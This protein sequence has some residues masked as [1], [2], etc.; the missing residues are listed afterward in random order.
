LLI[1]QPPRLVAIDSAS[2]ARI[3]YDIR[4]ADAKRILKIFDSG[5]VVPLFTEFHV[6]E[7]VRHKNDTVFRSRV[8]LIRSLPFVAFPKRPEPIGNIGNSLE[9]RELEMRVLLDWPDAT[10]DFV[11]DKVRPKLINGFARGV[12]LYDSNIK[13]WI[14]YRKNF[15][16]YILASSADIA[17]FCHFPT[18]NA[19]DLDAPL[20]KSSKGLALRSKQEIARLINESAGSLVHRLKEDGDRRLLRA[21][22]RLRPAE[23]IA[24]E[25]L[26]HVYESTAVLHEMDGDFFE[27]LLRSA[28]IERDRLPPNPTYGDAIYETTFVPALGVHE[29]RL[30][31]PPGRLRQFVRQ[32]RVPSWIVWRQTNQ[33]MK[34]LKK[35]EGSSLNDAMIVPFALYIDAV[36]VDKRVFHCVQHR[37]SRHPLMDTVIARLFCS[38][39][40]R[41]L[42]SKLETM[43]TEAQTSWAS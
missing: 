5:R 10:L 20:P 21:N 19:P 17:S 26:N 27:N 36:E 13:W 22:D 31:L 14:F 34:T 16:S 9:A 25:L 15:A 11:V 37:R 23:E 2:W 41:D 6:E 28:G 40:L 29:R 3:A 39:G 42:A 12:D 8:E 1:A 32:D 38:K 4:A 43:A 30:N 24:Y 7:L 35:A 18:P 33:A